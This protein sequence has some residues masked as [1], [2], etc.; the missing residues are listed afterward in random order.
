ERHPEHRREA[1]LG[2]ADPEAAEREGGVQFQTI[3]AAIGLDAGTTLEA[4][5]GRPIKIVDGGQLIT[6]LFS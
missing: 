4:P 1:E 6:G 2:R 5:N 3:C